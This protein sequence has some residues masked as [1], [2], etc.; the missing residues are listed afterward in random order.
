[1]SLLALGGTALSPPHPA[2]PPAGA[3][4]SERAAGP[5]V[6]VLWPMGPEVLCLLLLPAPSASAGVQTRPGA[7]ELR[8]NRSLPSSLLLISTPPPP[9]QLPPSSPLNLPP[10]SGHA[11]AGRKFLAGKNQ[12]FNPLL[13][14]AQQPGARSPQ[15]CDL[16]PHLPPAAPPQPPPGHLPGVPA[17]ERPPVGGLRG[18]PGAAP[19]WRSALRHRARPAAPRC[20]AL[21]RTA[22]H[23]SAPL[24]SRLRPPEPRDRTH[25]DL[26]R[27][28]AGERQ[29]ERKGGKKR[30]LG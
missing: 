18:G 30:K 16:S 7:A 6:Q 13:L 3:G 9:P 8:L 26:P 10:H 21:L 15:T 14:E 19:R 20:S 28:G 27:E 17:A 12:L 25:R 23:R 4:R 1:M 29:K 5:G 24:R 2:A 11:Q 22:P